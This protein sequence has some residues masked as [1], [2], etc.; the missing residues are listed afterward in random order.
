MSAVWMCVWQLYRKP[1]IVPCKQIGR[2]LLFILDKL[3][4]IIKC[5]ILITKQV[6][7]CGL[8]KENLHTDKLAGAE[9]GNGGNP[10]NDRFWCSL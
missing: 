2:I 7:L 4:C 9:R 5:F 3:L 6:I 10:G 8:W 1:S